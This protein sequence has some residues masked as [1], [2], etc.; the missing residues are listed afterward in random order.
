[1]GKTRT[2]TAGNRTSPGYTLIELCVVLVLIGIML[3]I[4]APQVH[5]M[6]YKDSAHTAMKYIVNKSR[7]L[8]L[9]AVRENVDYVMHFD[10]DHNLLWHE[11]SDMTAAKRD[12]MKKMSFKLPDNVKILQVAIVGGGKKSQGDATVKFFRRGY[13]QPAMLY[14]AQ[15]DRV[16]T[17]VFNPFSGTA[18]IY[19]RLVEIDENKTEFSL[20]R[21]EC[22]FDMPWPRTA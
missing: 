9:D 13:T 11:T 7:E 3:F 21:M 22:P 5:D 15:N 18:R 2:S 12:E 14:L 6:L 1:M 16:F 17:L 20:S 10:L 4:A 19:D 8:R